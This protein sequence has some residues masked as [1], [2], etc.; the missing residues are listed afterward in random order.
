MIEC[1]ILVLG[2]SDLNENL[3]ISKQAIRNIHVTGST[4]N[5]SNTEYYPNDWLV[6]E[7][8]YS[9]EVNIK[10]IKINELEQNLLIKQDEANFLFIIALDINKINDVSKYT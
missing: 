6:Q 5:V 7:N 4:T 10:K 9:V 2:N 1:N 8:N 3:F